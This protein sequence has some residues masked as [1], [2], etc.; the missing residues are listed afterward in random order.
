MTWK[1]IIFTFA[2]GVETVTV[3]DVSQTLNTTIAWGGGAAGLFASNIQ[4]QFCGE[5]ASSPTADKSF[6]GLFNNVAM[7]N[8]VLNATEKTELYNRG[9]TWDWRKHS[10][11]AH[12][13]N[14]WSADQN[15]NNTTIVD[16][17]ASGANATIT[18]TGSTQFFQQCNTTQGEG[19]G[20]A[21][22]RIVNGGF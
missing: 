8:V 19:P 21:R 13:T 18:K 12:M 6:G 10:Q 16:L 11:A 14:W 17:I 3:N 4:M 15:S 7:W 1:L 9:R 2:N 5:N 20:V 22:N